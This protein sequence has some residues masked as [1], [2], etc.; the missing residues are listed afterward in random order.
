METIYLF[1]SGG[2]D[3]TFLLYYYCILN[4]IYNVVPIY[5]SNKDLDG[6]L[7]D[8]NYN[9]PR[10]LIDNDMLLCRKPM[11]KNVIIWGRQNKNEELNSLYSIYEKITAIHFINYP[12]NKNKLYPLQIINNI[13]L[14]DDIINNMKILSKY[15]DRPI[16]QYTF[17]AQ[18]LK[19]NKHIKLAD[20][21]SEYDYN[22]TVLSKAT[23][24]YLN[25]KMNN[26]EMSTFNKL[27]NKLL[28]T[29]IKKQI[30]KQVMIG[31][32]KKYKFI[33][34]LKMTISCW[35]PQKN[36]KKCNNCYPCWN[37]III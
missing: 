17:I 32:A 15:F 1:V 35:N 14:D 4:P 9:P 34:I 7:A 8:F 25:N 19:N 20:I 5:L 30:S 29:L 12:K 33:N 18:V 26:I 27:F 36:G 6:A 13:K 2:M 10:I 24:D 28:F 37:R 22:N 11:K 3:S 23:I 16:R 31:I 21:G